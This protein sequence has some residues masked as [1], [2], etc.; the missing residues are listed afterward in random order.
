M[1]LDN[2]KIQKNY[3]KILEDIKKYS[4]HPEKVKI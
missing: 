4:S 2:V 1:E 3:N